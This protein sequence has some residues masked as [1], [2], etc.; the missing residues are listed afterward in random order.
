[1]SHAVTEVL[2]ALPMILV[3]FIITFF[4]IYRR[5]AIHPSTVSLELDS[6]APRGLEEGNGGHNVPVQTPEPTGA[7]G[8][9]EHVQPPGS[10]H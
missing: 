3:M 10:D 9:T 5:T 4:A 1:M 2:W 8:P 7:T 6:V